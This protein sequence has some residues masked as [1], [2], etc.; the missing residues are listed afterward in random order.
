MLYVEIICQ[1]LIQSLLIPRNDDVA[2]FHFRRFQIK[3]KRYFPSLQEIQL[4]KGSWTS[5]IRPIILPFRTF[6]IR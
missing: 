5:N 4:Q 3:Q 2:Y 1:I 6:R